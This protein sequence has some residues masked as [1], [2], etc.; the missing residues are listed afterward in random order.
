M[1]RF[2]VSACFALV[3][4]PVALIGQE[5]QGDPITVRFTPGTE[6]VEVVDLAVYTIGLEVDV[7]SV[8]ALTPTQYDV[9]FDPPSA[10]GLLTG[11]IEWPGTISLHHEG[12][13]QHD[14]M[15]GSATATMEAVGGGTKSATDLEVYATQ[16]G[17][18]DVPWT[19]VDTDPVL[20]YSEVPP[21]DHPGQVSL[22]FRMQTGFGDEPD[23]YT[24]DL[25]FYIIPSN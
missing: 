7:E 11:H 21:G 3:I 19:P 25:L 20:I 12:N 4:T 10:S 17:E 5:P 6:T 9:V 1:R 18:S 22:E 24:L 23:D 16:V 14:L 13:V 2:L 8:L 15:V